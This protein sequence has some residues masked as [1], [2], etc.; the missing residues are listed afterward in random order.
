MEQ[1]SENIGYTEDGT[2][3]PFWQLFCKKLVSLEIG[4]VNKF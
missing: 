3:F 4:G 2:N 1:M